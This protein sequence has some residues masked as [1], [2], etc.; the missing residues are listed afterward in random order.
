MAGNLRI[1]GSALLLAI[2]AQHCRALP[3]P[4]SHESHEV[5]RTSS[6]TKTELSTEL[7]TPS[8]N[9]TA[10]DT[11]GESE[12]GVRVADVA[13]ADLAAVADVADA[14]PAVERA[15]VLAADHAAAVAG[16]GGGR[17]RRALQALK[18]K[19]ADKIERENRLALPI[20]INASEEQEQ[21]PSPTNVEKVESAEAQVE[22]TQNGNQDNNNSAQTIASNT[23]A[24]TEWPAPVFELVTETTA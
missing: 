22:T 23:A 5:A 4:S 12:G 8:S 10:I 18:I 2:I 13:A 17:K 11:L 3:I 7:V 16:C 14:A 24:T 15:A 21:V 19:L 20:V 9:T 1:F 6:D